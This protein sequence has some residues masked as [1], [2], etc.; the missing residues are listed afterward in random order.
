LT[1]SARGA[2]RR[3]NGE[4]GCGADL[5]LAGAPQAQRSFTAREI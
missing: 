2:G 5:V 1:L 3:Q 4:R